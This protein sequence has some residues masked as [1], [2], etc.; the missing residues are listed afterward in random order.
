[1]GKRQRGGRGE[2]PGSKR[3]STAGIDQETS[4]KWLI[5]FKDVT[6]CGF[7]T[8]CWAECERGERNVGGGGQGVNGLR[9]VDPNLMKREIIKP[10][11]TSLYSLACGLKSI[12]VQTVHQ[13][14]PNTFYPHTLTFCVLIFIY[15]VV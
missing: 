6:W 14:R 5:F 7:L 13:L 8:S 10:F 1:M 9:T 15:C 3:L 12:W 2:I 4:N 11:L